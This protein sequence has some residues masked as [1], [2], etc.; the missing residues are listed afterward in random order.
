MN[1]RDRRVMAW[2]MLLMGSLLVGCVSDKGVRKLQ[3]LEL[4]YFERMSQELANSQKPINDILEKTAV[5]ERAAIREIVSFQSRLNNARRVYALREMLT[6]P[7]NDSAEF[8]QVT[9][10]KIILYHLAEAIDA[11]NEKA[12]AMSAVADGQRKQLSQLYQ[13]LVSQTSKVLEAEKAL[14]QY[15]NQAPPQHFSDSLAE[16]GRQLQA[17]NEEIQRADQQNT[18]IRAMSMVG[19]QSEQRLE[20]VDTALDRFIELWPQLNKPKEK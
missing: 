20:Q 17:F 12:M 15:L 5:S 9:R 8:I 4:Q 14:H 18:V 7:K 6:A 2:G 11:Q 13:D 3:A 1:T 10:N 19:Q 16:A